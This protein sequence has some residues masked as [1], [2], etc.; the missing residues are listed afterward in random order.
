MLSKLE[1]QQNSSLIV[2]PLER[3]DFNS[4]NVNFETGF[5]LSP[6]E[7]CLNYGCIFADDSNPLA[8]NFCKYP[9]D[10]NPYEAAVL[11]RKYFYLNKQ[12]HSKEDFWEFVALNKGNFKP[13]IETKL[14][15]CTLEK[16]SIYSESLS[17]ND[18]ADCM[19][20]KFASEDKINEIIGDSFGEYTLKDIM[21][22]CNCPPDM[23]LDFY[24]DVY[25]LYKKQEPEQFLD[26]EKNFN[27]K[28]FQKFVSSEVVQLIKKLKA[29]K[30]EKK[31]LFQ[32]R[33]D[34]SRYYLKLMKNQARHS[35]DEFKKIVLKWV[36]KRNERR[37]HKKNVNHL[38]RLK[39]SPGK[40]KRISRKP[41][42][43]DKYAELT[44]QIL[45]EK[46]KDAIK[47]GQKF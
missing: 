18:F 20:C 32:D 9:E 22:T 30:I 23:T 16:F 4:L 45:L 40:E 28:K 39:P 33:Q 1:F 46:A 24:D 27:R 2:C 36:D 10:L 43:R 21:E 3:V 47:S 15:S 12:H 42:E 34:F 26:L 14:F 38:N 29:L 17:I 13:K 44:I 5:T 6:L 31:F 41:I 37:L 11:E 19:H 35:D 7:T 25:C 8:K